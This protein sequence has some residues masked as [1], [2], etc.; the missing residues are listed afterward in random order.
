[1]VL[2]ISSAQRINRSILLPQHVGDLPRACWLADAHLDTR[3]PAQLTKHLRN[4]VVN[5]GCIGQKGNPQIRLDS[6]IRWV[7]V[8]DE[9]QIQNGL[10]QLP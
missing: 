2:A 10:P 6:G 5:R 3:Q 7:G 4:Q 1:M 9:F 8:E